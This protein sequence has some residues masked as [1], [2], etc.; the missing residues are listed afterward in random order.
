MLIRGSG[1]DKQSR[2]VYGIPTM[3][4]RAILF[5]EA[6]RTVGQECERYCEFILAPEC[7]AFNPD[8]NPSTHQAPY[9]AYQRWRLLL[10]QLET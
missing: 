1:K 10:N 7:P 6:G 5:P 2:V 9:G 8:L 4:L 3:C